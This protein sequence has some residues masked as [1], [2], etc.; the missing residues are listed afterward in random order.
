[1]N[2]ASHLQCSIT[3]ELENKV[4]LSNVRIGF[5]T[6]WNEVDDKVFGVPAGVLLEVTSDLSKPFVPLA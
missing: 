4:H 2:G 3:L 6:F 1:M 5:N